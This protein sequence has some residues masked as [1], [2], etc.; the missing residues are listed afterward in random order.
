M[1][2]LHGTARVF[3]T[4]IDGNVE[5]PF[6]WEQTVDDVR[7]FAYDRLVQDKNQV[8]LNNTW[9]ERNTVRLENDVQLATLADPKKQPGKEPDLT[10]TLAWTQ[11]GGSSRGEHVCNIPASNNR[12][13]I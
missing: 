11:Q 6:Q 13:S 9:I 10:L 5:H 7:R 3:V 8:S 4:S 1:A 12:C 2:D